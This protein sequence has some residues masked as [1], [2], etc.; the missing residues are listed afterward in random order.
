MKIPDQY[1]ETFDFYMKKG[2]AGRVGFGQRPAL[3][4]IDMIHGFTDLRS[5][6]ASNMEDQIEA[7]D[8]LLDIARAKQITII[9]SSVAYDANL[10]DAGIWIRK[11]PSA[12]LLVEGSK[13]V[14]VDERLHRR[15]N[16]MLLVKKYASCFFGT[17]LATRLINR[18]IDTLLITG[19]TTSGCV[20][21]T[22]VD[23][24]SYGLH[25]IVVQE[26]VGDRAELPHFANLFDIDAKYG[27]VISLEEASG[28]LNSLP[29]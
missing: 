14:G 24:C 13:W 21:A 18:G 16:E 29:K 12:K 15:P 19:C 5:P 26:T 11:I 7:I 23:S 28:Y 6:L 1:K 3:I 22:A 4:V 25:T 20:R 27:D 9:F 8:Q 10:Q 17:D 2:L